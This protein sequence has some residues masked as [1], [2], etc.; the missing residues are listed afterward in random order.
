MSDSSHYR[1]IA[2][3]SLFAKKVD[4]IILDRCRDKVVSSELQFGFKAN[5]STN[6]CSRV[7]KETIPYYK[8]YQTPVICTFLDAS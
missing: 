3:S 6:M 5:H 2:L 1:G 7:L 8:Q 4:Y